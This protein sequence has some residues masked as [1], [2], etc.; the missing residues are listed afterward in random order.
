MAGPIDDVRKPERA[1]ER[2]PKA[3]PSSTS[4]QGFVDPVIPTS[5]PGRPLDA[6]AGLS[7]L[8]DSNLRGV[9]LTGSPFLD[10]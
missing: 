8:Y 1:A 6:D 10:R 4:T 5:S 2:S 7:R 9:V 3:T